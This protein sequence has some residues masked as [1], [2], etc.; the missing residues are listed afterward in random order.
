MLDDTS[1]EAPALVAEDAVLFPDM[2]VTAAVH[3]PRNVAAAGQAM[4][5]RNLIVFIPAAGADAVAGSIGTLAILHGVQPIE[6]GGAQIQSKGLWRVRVE[7]ALADR[8]YVRVRFV[9]AGEEEVAPIGDSKTIATVRGQIDEFV[10]LIPGLP[11]EIVSFLKGIDSPGKLA[12]QCA[13]SPFF[14]FSDRLDLLRT[15]D[16]R[17][18]LVKISRLFEKQLRELKSLPQTVTV[19]ECPTCMDFADRAFD[20]GPARG[21]EVAKDFLAHVVNEHPD[22]LLVL[23]AET[24]GP[25]FLRKRA[26]R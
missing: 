25:A 2:E 9:K 21:G 26:L 15:P 4:K 8:P 19:L 12:D 1:Y 22:E 17:L 18:R 7:R 5:E 10:K 6:A 11:Q 20:L 23:L 14:T 3:D 13:Y 24:Y 16:P